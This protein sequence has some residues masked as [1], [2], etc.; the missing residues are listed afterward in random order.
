MTHS[1][2]EQDNGQVFL[3]SINTVPPVHQS[4]LKALMFDLRGV[5]NSVKYLLLGSLQMYR[6]L[7]S[8]RNKLLTEQNIAADFLPPELSVDTTPLTSVDLTMAL[9]LEGVRA[10]TNKINFEERTKKT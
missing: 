10:I 9:A 3:V 7:N 8:I 2:F 1:F 6:T 4:D 5:D